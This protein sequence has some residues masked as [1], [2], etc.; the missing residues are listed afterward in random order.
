MRYVVARIRKVN[1]ELA[2][3]IYVTDALKAQLKFDRRW[4]D[5]VNG[6]RNVDEKAEEETGQMIINKIKN[7][8]KKG[9]E[10]NEPI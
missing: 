6:T 4:I 5:I 9:G 1:R 2:Y 8:L 7:K 10:E 3:R